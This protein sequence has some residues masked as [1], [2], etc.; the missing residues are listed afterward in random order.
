[1]KTGMALFTIAIALTAGCHA[2]P[3]STPVITKLHTISIHVKD[4]QIHEDVYCFLRED[5]QL[6]LVYEPVIH[7]ERRYV[8]L[9]AGN[10]VLEPCGP[11][12]NIAYAT[13]N[14]QGIVLKVNSLTAAIRTLKVENL[15]GQISANRVQIKAPDHWKFSI[16]LQE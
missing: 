12:G 8:G 1:M 3:N 9:W 16:S 11:Y 13:P 7:G 15:L 5:L 14:F 2:T 10:L 4:H 6:P